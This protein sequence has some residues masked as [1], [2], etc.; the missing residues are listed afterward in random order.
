MLETLIEFAFKL[1]IGLPAFLVDLVISPGQESRPNR[2]LLSLLV[3]V[4]LF[5]ICGWALVALLL[6]A[7]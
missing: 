6:N 4:F 3:I 1:V 7:H 5:G 2:W